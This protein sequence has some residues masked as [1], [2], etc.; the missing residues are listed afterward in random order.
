[1]SKREKHRAL[2]TRLESDLWDWRQE[3]RTEGKKALS[4]KL[5]QARARW[6]FHREG[7]KDFKASDGWYWKW[8]SRWQKQPQLS[9]STMD[10][11]S[12]QDIHTL[13]IDNEVPLV[14]SPSLATEARDYLYYLQRKHQFHPIKLATLSPSTCSTFFPEDPSHS[15]SISTEWHTAIDDGE[16]QNAIDQML[17]HTIMFQDDPRHEDI[18]S[19][20]SWDSLEDA[21]HDDD[22]SKLTKSEEHQQHPD[23]QA[24]NCSFVSPFNDLVGLSKEPR[25]EAAEETS[26]NIEHIL[27]SVP[28]PP[29]MV[30]HE[31]EFFMS[32]CQPSLAD[33]IPATTTHSSSSN[34]N[35]NSHVISSSSSSSSSL[36]NSLLCDL[37]SSVLPFSLPSPSGSA[38]EQSFSPYSQHSSW[39]DIGSSS[40]MVSSPR[41]SSATQEPRGTSV[42]AHHRSL[43]PKFLN[44]LKER[45]RE[46]AR[47]HTYKE[48]AK[49]FGVHH[50]TV[51]GWVKTAST[52]TDTSLEGKPTRFYNSSFCSEEEA[53]Q[54][55]S[56][57]FEVDSTTLSSGHDGH[58]R[59]P[60]GDLIKRR[61]ERIS[62]PSSF[63]PS[64][65]P[66]HGFQ[67]LDGAFIDWLA[68]CRRNHQVL[69]SSIVTKQIQEIIKQ[70]GQ[71]SEDTCKWFL[72][73]KNRREEKLYVEGMEDDLECKRETQ[74]LAYPPAFKLEVALYATQ[75]SQYAASKIFS[76]ARRRIFDW[77]KQI[78]KLKEMVSSGLV[79]KI[80]GRGPKNK[81]I[82]L[83]L[84]KWYCKNKS[85]GKRP[86][87]SQVQSKAK[88]I[89]MARGYTDMKC[90]YGWFK[91]WSQ[92]FKI[93]LRYSYDEDLLEWVWSQF[94]AN[95][96]ISH[97]DLQKFGLNVIGRDDASFKASSGWAMRFCKRNKNLMSPYLV[98]PSDWSE[99]PP[100]LVEHA[101]EFSSNTL[102]LI[103]EHHLS[104]KRIGFMDEVPLHL[105][106]QSHS[107]GSFTN[108]SSRTHHPGFQLRHA[109][110]QDCSAVVVLSALADGTLLTPLLILKTSKLG[111]SQS[112]LVR[113]KDILVLYQQSDNQIRACDS[114]LAQ[115]LSSVWFQHVPTPNLMIMDSFGSH[116]GMTAR[117]F[118]S[119]RRSHLALIPPSCTPLV[120]PLLWGLTWRFKQC[121]EDAYLHVLREHQ[122]SSRILKDKCAISDSQIIQWTNDA[123]QA[124]SKDK[125]ISHQEFQSSEICVKASK[126]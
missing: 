36:N 49:K 5:V 23:H 80:T 46:Y 13:S 26:M 71:V 28:L 8:L 3:C 81:D 103:Q 38:S 9:H 120:Q 87:S 122:T 74:N 84:Y 45:V 73:W 95:N 4:K 62:S 18:I 25:N 69:S 91:R 64:A 14:D 40:S 57:E 75:H 17:E 72:L 59:L 60:N 110:F 99:L 29:I 117:A 105:N 85:Q 125:E 41:S 24:L 70:A 2:I 6:A 65:F 11:K 19:N 76:V 68:R 31:D 50:S 63:P 89:F 121:I 53:R 21:T 107:P 37:S 92:R 83:I 43:G 96:S 1:M 58:S 30:S 115:W 61:L 10:L 35:N 93:Q 42:I 101:R 34:N 15:G 48:T 27:D 113:H 32:D 33:A 118:V 51:S 54:F 66:S 106:P 100:K 108:K 82:D 22:Q 67:G 12:A 90:S 119:A 20:L 98:S 102:E 39:D 79:K 52:A 78:P 88:D 86:K 77:M 104:V 112:L 55:K 94:E 116:E 109:G 126:E 111:R 16:D 47:T 123:Y 7:M 114:V 97:L 124:V 44:Q 56:L